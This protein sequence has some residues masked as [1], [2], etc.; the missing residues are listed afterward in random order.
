MAFWHVNRRGSFSDFCS[1]FFSWLRIAFCIVFF[2]GYKFSG[3]SSI[4]LILC[5]GYDSYLYCFLWRRLCFCFLMIAFSIVSFR[6]GTFKL[7]CSLYFRMRLRMPI[8]MLILRGDSLFICWIS[9][10]LLRHL[11]IAFCMMTFRESFL[12]NFSSISY[13]LI[14]NF[15][16]ALY[17]E[18]CRLFS[19]WWNLIFLGPDFLF[20]SLLPNLTLVIFILVKMAFW[21]TARNGKTL[22]SCSCKYFM[23]TLS[24]SFTIA[25]NI[26]F[27][28]TVLSGGATFLIF[29]TLFKLS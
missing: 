18:L 10:Y 14:R 27:L 3:S 8:C 26:A 11:S 23:T 21:A 9:F 20:P 24:W 4:K 5:L 12:L 17:M 13:L 2:R 7:S 16:I 29:S 6:G 1:Y 28:I 22:P 25:A 19:S 15:I